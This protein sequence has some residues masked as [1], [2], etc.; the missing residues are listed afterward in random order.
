MARR[1]VRDLPSTIDVLMVDGFDARGQ[2]AQLCSQAFYDSCVLALSP[3][4]LLVVNLHRDHADYAL[5]LERINRSFNGTTLEA[6][7]EEKSNGIIFA[8]K[9]ATV[10]QPANSLRKSLQH[11]DS[12]GRL[13]LTPELARILWQMKNPHLP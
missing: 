9:D 2:S 4:G 8:F 3:R 1:W 6:L 10:L 12:Q 7:A 13:Q 11:L 5:L